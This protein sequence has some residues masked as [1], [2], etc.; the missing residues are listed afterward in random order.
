MSNYSKGRLIKVRRIALKMTQEE[1]ASDICDVVT[2]RRYESGKLEPTDEKF[3]AIMQK[4]NADSD[5]INPSFEIYGFTDPAVYEEFE[6]LLQI[7]NLSEFSKQRDVFLQSLNKT[8]KGTTYKQLLVRINTLSETD[9]EKKINVLTDALRLTFSDF[10][11]NKIPTKMLSYVELSII[12]DI[13]ICYYSLNNTN[14]I[15]FAVKIYNNLY[16]YFLNMM[17]VNNNLM[18]R[19]IVL[20]YTS[21]LGRQHLFTKAILICKKAIFWSDNSICQN[22]IYNLIY[23]LGWL[24]YHLG[25]SENNT[26]YIQLSKKYLLEAYTLNCFFDESVIGRKIIEENYN[27][28]FNSNVQEEYHTQLEHPL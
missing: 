28:W 16:D 8:I 24:Y 10:N 11:I 9:S 25:I 14:S 6:R 18:F 4:L 23:N 27:S 19:K 5:L 13:A 2:L 26:H 15:D 3:N 1:L 17:P 22:N 7:H 20:N 21:I 12:N